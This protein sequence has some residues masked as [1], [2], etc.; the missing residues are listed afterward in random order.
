MKEEKKKKPGEREGA[1]TPDTFSYLEFLRFKLSQTF[2]VQEYRSS[3]AEADRRPF[4]PLS[5][6]FDMT[7]I[8]YLTYRSQATYDTN[9]GEWKTINHDLTVSDARGD[10]ATIGYRYTQ[11]SVQEL[12][13]NLK[14]VTSRTLDL[15]YV[16]RRNMF[17]QRDL[18][19]TYIIDYHKQCW[20]VEFTYSDLDNDKQYLVVFNLYGIGKVGG[21]GAKPE[22]L[23]PW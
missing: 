17:D 16:Q 3:K 2:D 7:P 12:N 9:D 11:D 13:L 15:K 6:E 18:E 8:K 5:L 20:S 4:S 21:L 23:R 19:K 1:K 14:A 22:S 10:A